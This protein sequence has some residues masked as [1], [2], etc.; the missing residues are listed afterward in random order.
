MLE[1]KQ[2]EN[3]AMKILLVVISFLLV[4]PKA[5]AKVPKNLKECLI[6]MDAFLNEE[7]QESFLKYDE[8][9]LL[10]AYNMSLGNYIRNSWV[11]EDAPLYNYFKEMCV[12]DNYQMSQIIMIS[13]HRSK[14]H[15]LINLSDQVEELIGKK[16]FKKCKSSFDSG[17]D[18]ED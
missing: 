5:E 17:M 14:L 12:E 8:E 18:D 15:K 13:Y 3:Q 6:E 7:D 9:S 10:R 11:Y 2:K 16:A 4:I 1:F